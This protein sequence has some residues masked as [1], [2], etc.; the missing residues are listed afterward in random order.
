[1]TEKGKAI[2]VQAV[3]DLVTREMGSAG[4]QEFL[5]YGDGWSDP[6]ECARAVLVAMLAAADAPTREALSLLLRSD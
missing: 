2:F 6:E 3:S 5:G 4:C 1:M